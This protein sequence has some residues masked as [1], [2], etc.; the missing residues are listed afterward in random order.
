[1]YPRDDAQSERDAED[2][3][4]ELEDHPVDRASSRQPQ[5]LKHRQPCRQTDRERRED[6]VERDREREL[7]ARQRKGCELH[8]GPPALIATDYCARDRSASRTGH[9][10]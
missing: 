7:K 4:P 8:G 1:H 3:E 10:K 2:L 6:D 5:R 9:S